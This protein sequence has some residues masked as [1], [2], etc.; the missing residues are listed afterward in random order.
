[1]DS[2][3]YDTELLAIPFTPG[4]QFNDVGYVHLKDFLDKDS[5][6]DL[7]FE[8][9]RIVKEGLTSFDAQCKLSEAIHSAPI[10]DN[11][12]EV[13]LPN[14]EYVS[15][16]KL[17]PTYSYARL[18]K[19]NEIL[20]PHK[21]RP[22]CEISATITLGFDKKSWPIFVEG[23]E[24]IL[25]VGDA[26]LYKGQE[27]THW[28]EKFEGEWQAQVFLHYVDAEGK[29][30]DQKYDGRKNL[31]HK[32]NKILTYWHFPSAF[33]ELSCEKIIKSCEDNELTKAYV[34][35]NNNPVLDLKIRDVNKVQLPVYRGVGATLTGMGISANNQGW[36]FN[37]THSNQC[38]FLQYT[39]DGHYLEHVDNM[40]TYGQEN[41]TD[42]R[43]LTVLVFLNDD[44][45]G[46]KFFLKNES[47][48]IY[49][50]QK[51]GD[52]IVFPSFILHGVEPV[53]NGK[54]RT[55]V[56]WLVG[57]SFK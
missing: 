7:V 48:K 20:E 42:A 17:L 44:F 10:F 31:S 57:P 37:I 38:E 8:L 6:K 45:E 47:E 50:P 22:A 12:L 16:K 54:R 1:M 43:K 51:A 4:L 55:I 18:Y 56:T 40:L 3:V 30:T 49:P 46:G 25:D 26:L 2:V 24:F 27:K 33:T 19:N 21:D 13:L 5:C 14:F 34:G 39:K 52:V 23:K 53:L 35:Y 29:Y 32:I 36:Q 15:G 11:L 9:K 28:R 41:I